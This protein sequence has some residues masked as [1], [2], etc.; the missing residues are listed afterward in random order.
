MKQSSLS[1]GTYGWVH[2]SLNYLNITILLSLW[3]S[4]LE[5]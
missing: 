2:L 3:P 1:N 4:E 5:H